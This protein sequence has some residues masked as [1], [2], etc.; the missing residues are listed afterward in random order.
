MLMLL[1]YNAALAHELTT[2]NVNG[3]RW[4]EDVWSELSRAPGKTRR[5]LQGRKTSWAMPAL[6]TMTSLWTLQPRECGNGLMTSFR[7]SGK[8]KANGSRRVQTVCHC[9]YAERAIV[10]GDQDVREAIFVSEDDLR[11]WLAD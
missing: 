1:I 2:D 3:R 8:A 11:V 9:F 5:M 10:K 7:G 6:T 4:P